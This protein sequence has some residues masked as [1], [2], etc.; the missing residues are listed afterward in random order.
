MSRKNRISFRIACPASEQICTVGVKVRGAK[1]AL[2]G[3]LLG[4]ARVQLQ[5]GA[6]RTVT[7]RMS[8][9]AAKAVRR[10]TLRARVILTATDATG[11]RAV[12]RTAV[13]IRR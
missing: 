9:K 6:R 7:V 2:A 11:N 3:R 13:R 8:K 10:G 12:T 1:G 5:G 4:R